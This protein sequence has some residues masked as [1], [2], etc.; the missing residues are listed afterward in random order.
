MNRPATAIHDEQFDHEIE[1]LFRAMVTAKNG[2]VFTTS[3]KVAEVFGKRHD[4]VIQAIENLECDA[5]FAKLN[6]QV[7]FENSELQNG[8]PLK[9]YNITK[10][11]FIFA[12]MGFTGKKAARLKLLYIRAFNWMVEQLQEISKLRDW[13]GDFVRRDAESKANGS[14]HGQGLARRRIEKQQLSNEQATLLAK[15]Q[16]VLMLEGE[17]V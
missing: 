8:K 7:C 14:L 4:N 10:D 5:D 9:Y 3:R 2:E 1:A 6:F 17:A 15:L 16:L 13:E 12:V 11:G